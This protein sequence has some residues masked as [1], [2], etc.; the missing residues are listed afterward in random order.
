MAE[1]VALLARND[2][3]WLDAEQQRKVVA[4]RQQSAERAEHTIVQVRE[5]PGEALLDTL[6]RQRFIGTLE[7]PEQELA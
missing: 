6:Q 5:L 4:F 2:Q 3:T 1:V 7:P